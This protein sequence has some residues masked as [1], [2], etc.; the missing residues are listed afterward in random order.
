MAGQSENLS[1]T[2]GSHGLKAGFDFRRLLTWQAT[3]NNPRGILGSASAEGGYALAGWLMGYLDN[4]TTPEGLPPSALNQSRWAAY[5]MDDWKVSRKLTVNLGL[6]WDFFQV[7]VDALGGVRSLRL[8]VLSQASDGRLLPTLV[9]APFTQNYPLTSSDNRYFMPRSGLAYRVTDK[10]I[11]R[12]GAGWFVNAQQLGNLAILARQPPNGGA[13][14]FNSV[15]NV[16]GIV[17]YTYAGQSYSLQ[18]REFT[19][20]TTILTL[21]NA[22][23]GQGSV[24]P[25]TNLLILAPD[26]RFPSVWQWSFDI[27]RALPMKTLLTIAYVGSK[28]SNVDNTINSWNNPLPNPNTNINAMRP[29]QAYVSQGEGN[30]PRGI[31]NL[32]YLDSYANASYE[33]LQMTVEKHYSHGLLLNFNYVF[34]KALGEGYERNSGQV[35]GGTYQNPLDRRPDRGRYPFDTT[36][37]A[38]VSVVYEMPFLN[39]FRGVAG[40]FLAGW[41]VNGIITLHTGYPFGLSGGNLNTG[42]A[43]RPDRVADGRLGS[44]ATRQLWFDPTA[45]RRTDC[46]IPS[47]PDLCHFGSAAN[48]VLNTPGSR[49]LDASIYKNWKIKP[50]GETARLQFR[51]EAF[52]ATNTRTSGSPSESALCRPMRW[53]PMPRNKDKS[54]AFCHRCERRS[55]P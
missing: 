43:T 30:T 48:D 26:N 33:G 7:P 53:F 6:R 1:F 50:L 31:G 2:R 18:T 9:P 14:S 17:S 21:D 40:G 28:S 49:N 52:N 23:P 51:M 54:A 38:T 27:Q 55:L 10:W 32:R 41:Q 35:N 36:H 8:D 13:L 45:F 24:A 5:F 20:G 25:R 47:R 34:S 39:R 22:F 15:T 46:N 16:A 3:S 37:N 11:V 12:T 19:P 42:A 29:W 4:S 44:Q